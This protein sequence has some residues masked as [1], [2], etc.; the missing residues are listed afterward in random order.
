MAAIARSRLQVSIGWPTGRQPGSTACV[1][2]ARYSVARTQPVAGAAS[3]TEPP[4]VSSWASRTVSPFE[5][6]RTKP[7]GAP[8]SARMRSGVPAGTWSPTVAS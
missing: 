3:S 1:P 6:T 2:S 7:G 5:R 8:P 4:G